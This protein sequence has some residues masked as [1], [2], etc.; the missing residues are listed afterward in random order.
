M[1]THCAIVNSVT[2]YSVI[3]IVVP[4]IFRYEPR[5]VD[6]FAASYEYSARTMLAIAT[7][8]PGPTA[9]EAEQALTVPSLA[10]A[11]ALPRAYQHMTDEVSNVMRQT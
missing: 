8:P 10:V 5:I 3:I 11:R 4:I 1:T 9:A 6:S 7:P 2:C